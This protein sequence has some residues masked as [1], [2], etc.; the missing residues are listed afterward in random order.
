MT[1]DN[2]QFN[3]SGS[4]NASGGRGG[5]GYGNGQ[6]GEGGDGGSVHFVQVGK[7]F[8][9]EGITIRDIKNIHRQY[10]L[11]VFIESWKWFRD[12]MVSIIVA[13]L[14]VA[15]IVYRLSWN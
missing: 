5:D 11:M 12:H 4:V 14:I 8:T 3:F 6:G 9:K 2:K 10:W 1:D 15:Y 7:E 13:G